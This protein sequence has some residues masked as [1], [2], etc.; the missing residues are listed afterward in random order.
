MHSLNVSMAINVIVPIQG[1][2]QAEEMLIS[3]VMP[4]MSI[5]RLPHGQYGYKGHVINL[6]QDITSFATSLPR[7][8]KDLDVLIVRK[9]GSENTHR[10][11]RV[12]RSVVL[13]ALLWL[14]HHNKYYRDVMI[15]KDEL[16]Q[17]PVDGDLSNL[18]FVENSSNL[19]EGDQ[20]QE[21]T[22]G[23]CDGLGSFVP[24][25]VQKKSEKDTVKSFVHQRQ[26]SKTSDVVPWPS[27]GDTPINE[28][29]TE[30]YISCAFPTLLA[31]GDAD[32]LAPRERTITVGNYFKHLMKYEDGRFAKHPRFRY[33][34]LNTEMR[35]RALQTGRIYIR[36]HPRDAR[37]TLEELKDM[38]NGEGEQLSRRVLHYANSLRGTRQFWFKQ[39]SR[40]ISMIDTLGM[41]T[42]F[43]TQ[44]C[45]QSVA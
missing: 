38:V 11:F 12:R 20:N 33:F 17:L 30:G 31:T 28:F 8:P 40:L 26:M 13:R 18:T 35:W 44:C 32:F 19:E 41:P 15:N 45:R 24:I 29:V 22:D 9:N 6:P 5:Y 7:N 14:K 34:A 21:E 27:R 43:F 2:S 39:R 37:L 16:S 3:A 25:V 42:I 36:Q 10:D 1:L 23:S 4:F